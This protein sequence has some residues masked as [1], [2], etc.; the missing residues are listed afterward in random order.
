[1]HDTTPREHRGR[2]SRHPVHAFWPHARAGADSPLVLSTVRLPTIRG[3]NAV[4]HFS[5][6][7]AGR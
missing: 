2:L 1:M 5:R 3:L 7:I 4:L 6:A